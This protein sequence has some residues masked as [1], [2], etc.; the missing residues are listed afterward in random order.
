MD[1]FIPEEYV[2]RRRIEKEAAD[3]MASTKT[4]SDSHWNNSNGRINAT[5]RDNKRMSHPDHNDIFPSNSNALTLVGDHLLSTL[6][7]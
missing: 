5:E 6:S 3:A 1:V 4:A 2:I 7:T